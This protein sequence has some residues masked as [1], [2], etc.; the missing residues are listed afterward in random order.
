MTE[1][2]EPAVLGAF[3]H[4]PACLTRTIVY[5]C[6]PEHFVYFPVRHG[7]R[8][9]PQFSGKICNRPPASRLFLTRASLQRGR[10]VD[11]S[12]LHVAKQEFRAASV[13]RLSAVIHAALPIKLLFFR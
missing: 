2:N 9:G 3:R 13:H 1:K 6:A 5:V 11:D 8:E 7:L 12:A 10:L 4:R